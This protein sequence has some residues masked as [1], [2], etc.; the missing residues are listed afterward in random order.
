MP[1]LEHVPG[2]LDLARLQC[3]LNDRESHRRVGLT[4]HLILHRARQSVACSD[5]VVVAERR[6][7]RVVDAFDVATQSRA[8]CFVRLAGH[9]R[10]SGLLVQRF[11]F[12]VHVV[13][14]DTRK[15]C[16]LMPRARLECEPLV[17]R[18]LVGERLRL[19]RERLDVAIALRDCGLASLC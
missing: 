16:D 9:D 19:R 10:L 14:D 18:Q 6:A 7:N 15:L 5:L 13:I 11:G 3:G 8:D 12:A 4:I 2:L 1:A 17:R